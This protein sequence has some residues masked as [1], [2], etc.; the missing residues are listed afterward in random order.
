MLEAAD[1]DTA[2]QRCQRRHT[3][4]KA[5]VDRLHE[6]LEHHRGKVI[7]HTPLGKALGY[8]RRQWP[9]LILFLHDGNIPLTNNRRERE[10][11]KLILGR[12][13][14]LFVWGDLG[15][16]RTANILTIVATCVSHG[17]NPR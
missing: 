10:L 17:I 5:H 2:E 13:N 4:S 8:L 1:G 11:R 16:I 6:R 12:R 14:W 7:P 3:H 9:R 15:A